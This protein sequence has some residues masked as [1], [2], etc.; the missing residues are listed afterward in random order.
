MQGS[1]VKKPDLDGSPIMLANFRGSIWAELSP[2]P[3][4]QPDLNSNGMGHL[5]A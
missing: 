5:L 1:A 2:E 3:S 4:D